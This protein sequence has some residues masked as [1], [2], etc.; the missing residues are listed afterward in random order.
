MDQYS[1]LQNQIKQIYLEFV[2]ADR[3]QIIIIFLFT[4]AVKTLEVHGIHC[5]PGACCC[6]P[7][8]PNFSSS[9]QNNKNVRQEILFQ[10]CPPPLHC[11]VFPYHPFPRRRKSIRSMTG[12]L[13]C[14]TL[15]P[16]LPHWRR[17]QLNPCGSEIAQWSAFHTYL[18][19]HKAYS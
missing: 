9:K 3:L 2:G 10:S 1:L 7:H 14:T 18:W 13:H 16:N 15:Y 12:M 4:E 8:P 5:I 6:P 17:K 11:Q 19:L